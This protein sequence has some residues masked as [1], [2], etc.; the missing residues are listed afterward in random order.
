MRKFLI[1][2]FFLSLL[3]QRSS[4]VVTADQLSDKQTQ[5]EELEK[6]VT[7]LRAQAKTLSSQIAYYD[8]QIALTTLKIS[9]SEILITTIS[10]KIDLLESRLQERSLLLKRQ[11]VQTY[12]QGQLDSF[13]LFVSSSSFSDLLSRF[14]YLQIIQAHNRR[15]L[16]DTQ[17]VQSNYSSQKQLLED[18]R[19]RLQAQ[20]LS[21]ANLR[22]ERDNL[23]KQTKNSESVYQRQLEQ[24]Q[25]ELLAIQA[26]LSSANREGPVKAGDTI[27]LMGNSG[28]PDC[29]TGT[30]LHF[31]VRQ[32]DQWVNA[33]SYLKPT[34]DK[35]GLNLGSGSWDWPLRGS[36]EITQRYGHTPYSYRYLYSGGIHTGI[37]IVS[38][39]PV[40]RAPA[41]GTLY[42][43]VQKCGNSALKIKYID[44]GSGLKTLYLHVQ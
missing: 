42:S 4:S 13:Q 40:I 17:V 22:L 33:E 36:I 43:S 27:A 19:A 44:H 15:F 1:A 38:S 8:S 14:K 39:D 32:G 24:A 2:L 11:I 28:F 12:K 30:H 21:L 20:K 34:T 23:L 6:K 29:S 37:D 10:G 9:Q 3:A 7:T 41:D 31:E 16:H 35:W 26:A 25:L 18:S 5:I